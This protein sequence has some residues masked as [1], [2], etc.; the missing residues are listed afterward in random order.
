MEKVY[1]AKCFCVIFYIYIYIIARNPK[2][3]NIYKCALQYCVICEIRILGNLLV[4]GF[5][6]V[7]NVPS[8]TCKIILVF[9]FQLNGF[10]VSRTPERKKC[11]MYAILL[12]ISCQVFYNIFIL[13]IISKENLNSFYLLIRF[14]SLYSSI[15]L[16]LTLLAYSNIYI[17]IYIYIYRSPSFKWVQ[18]NCWLPLHDSF[19]SI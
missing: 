7:Y 6:E 8:A 4:E 18:T 14:K 17:Y 11:M 19:I 5:S 15:P 13:D 10:L 2:F 1:F 16:A 12:P 3:T 9:C